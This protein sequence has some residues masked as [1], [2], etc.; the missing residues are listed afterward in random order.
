MRLLCIVHLLPLTVT[1]SYAAECKDKLPL[2]CK[3]MFDYC[4]SFI[5]HEYLRENCQYTCQQCDTDCKDFVACGTIKKIGGCN[6]T[7]KYD[8]D[9]ILRWCPRT[10]GTCPDKP[11]IP[12]KDPPKNAEVAKVAKKLDNVLKTAKI[13]WEEKIPPLEMQMGDAL[14]TEKKK[15]PNEL[16]DGKCAES[17]SLTGRGFLQIKDFDLVSQRK[18]DW[19]IKGHLCVH[20]VKFEITPKYEDCKDP[21]GC[22]TID[23]EATYRKEND[24]LAQGHVAFTINNNKGKARSIEKN[25]DQKFTKAENDAT[26]NSMAP[27]PLLR[28]P[29]E[30]FIYANMVTVTVEVIFEGFEDK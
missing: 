22:M 26:A 10:C 16:V 1:V 28:D 25:V 19:N 29:S 9:I 20:G 27:L 3:N 24:W 5:H 13:G 12:K 2:T 14:Q 30:G 21:M 18:E 6:P 17:T 15:N 7:T 23:L 8:R 11:R 4:T